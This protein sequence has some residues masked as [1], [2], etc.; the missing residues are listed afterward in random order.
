MW[1]MA[2]NYLTGERLRQAQGAL[3]KDQFH[4]YSEIV[5]VVFELAS[6]YTDFTIRWGAKNSVLSRL[7]YP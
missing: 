1:L 2:N 5:G 3:S 7:S 6:T 4:A